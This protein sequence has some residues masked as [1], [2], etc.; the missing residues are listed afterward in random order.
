MFDLEPKD[1]FRVVRI[2]LLLSLVLNAGML[3][4]TVDR[5]APEGVAV[6]VALMLVT[7]A[8]LVISED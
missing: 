4:S 3:I 5:G 8:A 7:V 6:S 1:R 2:A